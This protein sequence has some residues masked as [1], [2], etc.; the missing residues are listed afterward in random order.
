MSSVPNPIR[1]LVDADCDPTG[2][3][4]DICAGTRGE[5]ELLDDRIGE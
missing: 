1:A 3:T 4:V 5:F 2:I